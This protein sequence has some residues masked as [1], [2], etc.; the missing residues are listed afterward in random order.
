MKNDV[1]KLINENT[2]VCSDHHHGH[3]KIEEFEPS[4][5]TRAKELGYENYEEMQIAEHNKLVGPDDIVLFLGDFSF[6]SPSP[7]IRRYNGQKIL[8]VGNHDCRGDNAYENAGFDHVIRGT[9]LNYLGNIW[10][11]ESDNKHQSMMIIDINNKRCALTHYP[12]GF[13]EEYNSQNV[14]KSFSIQDTMNISYDIAK[15]LDVEY[16]IHGHLHSKIATSHEFKY[17]NVCL[18]Q[19]DFKPVKLCDL[20]N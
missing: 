15:S 12:I 8:I 7:H 2:W 16:I 1:L 9:Y 5:I 18:E 19:T 6:S 11:L 17:I 13:Y 4:R 10:E 14:Y 20:F 3:K